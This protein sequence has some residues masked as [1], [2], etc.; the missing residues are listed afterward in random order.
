MYITTI[1]SKGQ[2]TI[3]KAIREA[4]SLKSNDRLIFTRLSQDTVGMKM[5][6]P[7]KDL[8]SLGGSITPKQKPEN[9]AKVRQ[10][11]LR[12]IAATVMKRG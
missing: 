2:I 9:F 11:T 10:Q 4:L 5:V 1:T 8:L 6:K 12:K 7:K 3:P